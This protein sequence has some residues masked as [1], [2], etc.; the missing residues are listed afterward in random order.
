MTSSLRTSESIEAPLIYK[1]IALVMRDIDAISK[2]RKNAQQGYNFRGIDDVYNELHEPLARHGVFTL[3][4]VIEERTE[5]RTN[6]KGTTLI[7]RVLKIMFTFCAEDGS[8]VCAVVIGEG[9]DTG[10]KA[11]NKAMS[12]AHKYA[13]MQVFAIPTEDE[14][15]PEIH[16]HQVAPK[17]QP[18]PSFNKDDFN[19]VERLNSLLEKKKIPPHLHVEVA[20]M[21]HGKPMVEKTVDE[22]IAHL[23]G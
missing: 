5:E 17:P 12:V 1:K 8:K 11:S 18:K 9:M 22:I 21:L 13:L 4:E 6:A 10:D 16:H 2:A 15:D 7:Y 23:E 20:N 14:K 3:P 19:H